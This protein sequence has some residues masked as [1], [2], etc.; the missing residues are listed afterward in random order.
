MRCDTPVYFQRTTQGAYDASTGDYGED[1][2]TEERRWASVTDT[3]TETMTL[4]YGSLKQGSKTVRL[5]NHYTQP[6]DS[7]RIGEKQYRVDRERKLR[8]KQILIV[9]EVQ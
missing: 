7:I 2:R 1:I 5:Q 6:F 3:G 9:S 8:T 4:V